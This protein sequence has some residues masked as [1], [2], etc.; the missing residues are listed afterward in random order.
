MPGTPKHIFILRLA[1]ATML[2]LFL[3]WILG[4]DDLRYRGYV[5]SLAVLTVL[6]G[7]MRNATKEGGLVGEMATAAMAL[8]LISPAVGIRASRVA[9]A[10]FTA[11][12]IAPQDALFQLPAIAQTVPNASGPLLAGAALAIA[13]IAGRL[14]A[15]Y[16]GMLL[17]AAAA[18]WVGHTLAVGA[19]IAMRTERFEDAVLYSQAM[20]FVGIMVLIGGIIGFPFYR[21]GKLAWRSAMHAIIHDAKLAEAVAV[22]GEEIARVKAANSELKARAAA[23]EAKRAKEEEEA[24]QGVSIDELKKGDDAGDTGEKGVGT[25]AQSGEGGGFGE[26]DHEIEED[27]NDD[28]GAEADAKNDEEGEDS[29]P[30]LPPLE[31]APRFDIESP[32]V[33]TI[34]PEASDPNNKLSIDAKARMRRIVGGTALVCCLTAGWTATPPWFQVLSALPDPS[35]LVAVP[36]TDPGLSIARPPLDPLSKTFDQELERRNHGRLHGGAWTCLTDTANFGKRYGTQDRA[37]EQLA[38]PADTPITDL[39]PAVQL[40]RRRGVYRLGLTG[41]AD[42]PYGPLGAL[43]AWP[44][45]QVLIDRPPRALLWMKMGPRSLEELPLLPGR[46]MPSACALLIGETTTVDNLFQTARSL[47]SI[48]GDPRCRDGIAIVFPKDGTTTNTN[49][50]WRGC[51]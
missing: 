17:G 21:R 40:M 41:R 23:A 50:A 10:V 3:P 18:A 1:L 11:T 24:N 34:P 9:D 13:V 28:D 42:P 51:P 33:I 19:G 49:P 26:E 25:G 38:V 16:T 20:R 46:K 30:E 12:H 44:A 2:A 7:T 22:R 15:I 31:L 43:F 45:V 32:I 29:E 39:Y 5:L 14:G 8:L 4:P 35:T 47:G 6:A 36:T 48:Y 37:I 27:P